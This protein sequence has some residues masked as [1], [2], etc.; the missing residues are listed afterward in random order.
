MGFK[1]MKRK[2]LSLILIL[3]LIPFASIFVACGKDKGYNLNNLQSDFNKIDSENTNIDLEGGIISIDF[4]A[5]NHLQEVVSTTA[6]YN[7]IVNYNYILSNLMGF[8]CDYISVCSD[9]NITKDADLKNSLESDLVELKKS[10]NSLNNNIDMLGEIINISYGIDINQKTCLTR[11][12]NVLEA[13][14]EVFDK[15]TIF[16]RTLA[17]LYLNH[18]LQNENPN[19]FSVGY[20]NFDAGMIISKLKIK[21]SYQKA[22][23]SSN[24]V[25]VY[26]GED[27]AEKVANSLTIIDLTNYET[28]ITE[29]SKTF[30]EEIAIEKANN[31]DLPTNSNKERFYNLAIQAQNLQTI[32]NN[33][34]NKYY[35]ACDFVDYVKV[36][37]NYYSSAQELV[38]IDII[39]ENSDLI[40]EYNEVLVAMLEIVA[41]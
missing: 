31:Q 5:H 7:Q 3:M 4:S 32:L 21:I 30:T 18:A 9:N 19:V 15:A 28:N 27:M 14:Y 38:C 2:I 35:F 34:Q 25:E 8:A 11:Y 40:L 33:N 10:L 12:E 22:I 24:F 29:I 17:D 6:P 41:D 20:E 16:N 37:A 39:E 13:Y 1:I 26:I 23:L 36:K